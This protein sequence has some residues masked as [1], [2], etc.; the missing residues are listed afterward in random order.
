M[1]RP[2]AKQETF[3]FLK[4]NFLMVLSTVSQDC[5][6]ESAVTY[7]MFDDKN[8]GP[9]LY[10]VTRKD[11]R[12]F[13]N[14]EQ[15]GQVAMVVGT[16]FAS[17]TVQMQGEARKLGLG[18]VFTDFLKKLAKRPNLKQLYRG[19]WFPRNPFGKLPKEGYAFYK[20]KITWMRILRLS[21]K[22]DTVEYETVIS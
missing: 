17:R 16:D 12:K 19:D 6:P 1:A 3:T 4:I 22:G 18:E 14:L 7:F 21:E 13:A 20:V 9:S 11:S 8:G 15:N 10:F 2:T 5:V